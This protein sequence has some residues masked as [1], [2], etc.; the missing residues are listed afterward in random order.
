M[1]AVFPGM[2]AR[3]FALGGVCGL[4]CIGARSRCRREECDL[5][6]AQGTPV[7]RD[8]TIGAPS[9]ESMRV[10]EITTPTRTQ[11]LRRQEGS[12]ALLGRLQQLGRVERAFDGPHHRA[13]AA[14]GFDVVHTEQRPLADMRVAGLEPVG[15]TQ[16]EL[17][18]SALR[19]EIPRVRDLVENAVPARGEVVEAVRHGDVEHALGVRARLGN[20][21]AA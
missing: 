1:R 13:V 7:C 10:T 12:V 9:Q 17:R 8:E 14:L 20:V 11:R 4:K 15:G 2:S 19:I 5:G 6:P 21:R 3:E 18:E 16:F